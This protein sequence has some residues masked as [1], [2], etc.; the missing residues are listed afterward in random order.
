[1]DLGFIS[2]KEGLAYDYYLLCKD[3]ASEFVLIYF[4][5]NKSEVSKILAT[6][7]IDVEHGSG[8]RVKVV[9]SDNG[10][11]F[12]NKA[13]ELLF[14]KEGIKHLFSPPYVPQQNGMIER[15]IRTIKGMAR[16]MLLG[17]ELGIEAAHEAVRA[18]TY[19]RIGY[20]SLNHT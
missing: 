8:N 10:S 3:E 20:A 14:L 15:E 6:M 2:N 18:A 4:L 16:T 11:E 19:I 1:M 9:V 5:K 17:S 12:Q 13:N 7:I